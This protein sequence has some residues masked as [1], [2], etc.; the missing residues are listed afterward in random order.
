M[1]GEEA[2]LLL[3]VLNQHLTLQDMNYLVSKSENLLGC[4]AGALF[5]GHYGDVHAFSLTRQCIRCS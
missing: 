1:L 2:A 3:P 5:K 4:L